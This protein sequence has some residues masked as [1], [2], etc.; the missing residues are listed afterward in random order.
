MVTRSALHLHSFNR[1]FI[2]QLYTFFVVLAYM[3]N[4]AEDLERHN[5]TD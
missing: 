1:A 3:Y 2:R 4:S 5:Q